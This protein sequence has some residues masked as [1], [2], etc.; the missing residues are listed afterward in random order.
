VPADLPPIPSDRSGS[1]SRF[2]GVYKIRKKWMAEISIASEGGMVFLGTFDSEEEAGIMYARARYKYP[3]KERDHSSQ[4]KPC[5][6][7]GSGVEENCKIPLPGFSLR[8][9]SCP[10][11]I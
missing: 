7:T 4:T 3:V 9:V 6:S 1:A 10:A 8:A 5:P 11:D 2:K